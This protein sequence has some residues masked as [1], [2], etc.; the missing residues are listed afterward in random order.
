MLLFIK[1]DGVLCMFLLT[2]KALLLGSLQLPH[3]LLDGASSLG[4]LS[5]R[6]I[7]RALTEWNGNLCSGKLVR[8]WC[9]T[10]S[11]KILYEG[12]GSFHS[13]VECLV[14]GHT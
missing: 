4:H 1:P 7:R 11:Q 3:S 10:R 13:I 8:Y 9:N 5:T 14:G 12:V 2:N 6:Q